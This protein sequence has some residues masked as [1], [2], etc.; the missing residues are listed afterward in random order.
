MII[1]LSIEID[2]N[3]SQIRAEAALRAAGFAFVTKYRTSDETL[4]DVDNRYK[5]EG[6]EDVTSKGFGLGDT[7]I[8]SS[9]A[10]GSRTTKT[11]KII[12][13]VPAGEMPVRFA[14]STALPRATESYI[15]SVAPVKGNGA[16]KMYWPRTSALALSVRP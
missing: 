7:V 1:E 8:W 16:H 4:E 9:Q 10:Q 11:G 5:A 2:A 6:Y 12:K 13:I 15:V 3:H 14:A